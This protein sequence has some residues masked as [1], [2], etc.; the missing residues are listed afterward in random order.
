MIVS[1]KRF[2]EDNFLLRCNN[3]SLEIHLEP[4]GLLRIEKGLKN[5]IIESRD[6]K[7]E[8]TDKRE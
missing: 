3:Y 1:N 2:E 8:V 6:W 4:K 7:I 5:H